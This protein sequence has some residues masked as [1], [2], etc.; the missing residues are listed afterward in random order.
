M[1]LLIG[2]LKL[3]SVFV[4]AVWSRK[5]PIA[6]SSSF[7]SLSDLDGC[8]PGISCVVFYRFP[9]LRRFLAYRS[10]ELGGICYLYHTVQGGGPGHTPIQLLLLSAFSHRVCVGS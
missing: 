8:D 7:F 1:L 2:F 3:R 4:V 5:I 10:L 6:H 9:M